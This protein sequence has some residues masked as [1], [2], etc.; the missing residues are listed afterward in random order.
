MAAED[1]KAHILMLNRASVEDAGVASRTALRAS[2]EFLSQLKDENRA[3]ALLGFAIAAGEMVK[4][5]RVDAR[6]ALID[7]APEWAEEL[8]AAAEGLQFLADTA[9]RADPAVFDD[10]PIT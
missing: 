6:G 9:M 3:V 8:T 4:T 7:V 10:Q 5:E 2:M 1:S